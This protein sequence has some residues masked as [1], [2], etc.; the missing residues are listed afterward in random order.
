MKK[1]SNLT[2]VPQ[3]F[4]LDPNIITRAYG[5]ESPIIRD[6]L[7]FAANKSTMDFFGDVVFSLDEFCD[8]FGYIKDEMQRTLP[9]FVDCNKR[10]LPIEGGHCFD[11]V[12]EYALY[13][14]FRTSLVFSNRML[15]GKGFDLSNMLLFSRIQAIYKDT[16]RREK[17]Q[18]LV[19]LD[20]RIKQWQ[21][22]RYFLT[23][24]ELYRSIKIPRSI[25][26]TGG[27]R[28]FYLYLGRIASQI[29]EKIKYGEKASFVLT[30]DECAKIMDI[31]YDRNDNRKRRVKDFIDRLKVILGN[32]HFEYSFFK[33]GNQRYEYSIKFILP[34]ESLIHYDEK[35]NAVFFNK[36]NN[37]VSMQ[38]FKSFVSNKML[39][40]PKWV[41]NLSSDE[42]KEISKWFFNKS[43]GEID[44]AKK[45]FIGT[46]EEVFEIEYD[47]R[48]G[49]M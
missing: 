27:L 40:Y 2:R 32:H 33:G 10:D 21:M 12:F 17:R 3:V 47:G 29:K 9:Q 20:Y 4:T 36:L 24:Q 5:K 22:N 30:V 15:E 46:F 49:E 28:N 23:D 42:R 44:K 25:Q 34:K 37:G 8:A 41:N 39:N 6:I 18:Y 45:F 16:G 1:L 11:G 26:L 38:Y 48:F 35:L 31:S 7:V 13:K 14:G 43:N 19:E